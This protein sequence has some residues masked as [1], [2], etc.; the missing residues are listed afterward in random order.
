MQMMNNNKK[1]VELDP[2]SRTQFKYRLQLFVTERTLCTI[3]NI[4]KHE[5]KS[6]DPA[7]N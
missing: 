6:A 3:F 2:L 7:V 5:V 4:R 1:S